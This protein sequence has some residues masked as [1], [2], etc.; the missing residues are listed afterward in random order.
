MVAHAADQ[1]GNQ[2]LDFTS[3]RLTIK[4]VESVQRKLVR[5]AE[6]ISAYILHGPI[7]GSLIPVFQYSQ[8][9]KL[10]VAMHDKQAVKVAQ[11]RWNELSKERD[12][13]TSGVLEELTERTIPEP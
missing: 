9:A 13:W 12:Q 8:F 4:T 10:D 1:E 11:Q 2:R 3:L 6:V 7:H 5:T